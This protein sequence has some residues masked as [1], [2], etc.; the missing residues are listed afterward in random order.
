[1]QDSLNNQPRSSKPI[2]DTSLNYARNPGTGSYVSPKGQFQMQAQVNLNQ[3]EGSVLGGPQNQSKQWNNPMFDQNMSVSSQ[4][5]YKVF[6]DERQ[7]ETMRT[8]HINTKV[9]IETPKPNVFD[10]KTTTRDTS[11]VPAP[12]R[13]TINSVA[14]MSTRQSNI[15]KERTTILSPKDN[16]PLQPYFKDKRILVTGASSGIGRATAVW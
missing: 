4:K 11:N 16:R 13:P 15:P 8:T 7:E 3:R 1:M 9:L 14:K 6:G 12:M 2:F 10:K 5:K